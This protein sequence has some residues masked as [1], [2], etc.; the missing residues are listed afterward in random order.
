LI[1]K[2]SLSG[3][4]DKREE[5]EEASARP[6]SLVDI[7]AI[8]VSGLVDVATIPSACPR[9]VARRLKFSRSSNSLVV[10]KHYKP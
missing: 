2:A 4:V 5:L 7:N 9:I 8:T 10:P 1:I 3:L 6:N